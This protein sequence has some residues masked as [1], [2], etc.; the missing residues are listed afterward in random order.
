MSGYGF[1]K[2]LLLG[3]LMSSLAAESV[4]AGAWTR[5]KGG[6]YNQLTFNYYTADENF[7]DG[8]GRA[9]FENN[10]DFLDRN[11]AY[12]V[13]YGLSDSFTG[14]GSWSYKWLKY[15]DDSVEN[16][17]NGFSDLDLALKY[18]V[19]S[20]SGGVF[21]IQGLIKIPEAYDKNDAVPLGNSQYD[22]ELRLLYG[23]SLY[24][25]FPG[26][27]NVEAGYRFRAQ[28]P[29]DEF[30]YLLEAGVDITKSIYGRVKLD[31]ILGM[32]NTGN[33]SYTLENP[34]TTYDYDLGKLDV[35]VGWK[36]GKGWGIELGYRPEIYGK[37]T[38][39]GKNLSFTVIFQTQ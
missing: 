9:D 27:F 11:V 25:H 18:R 14:I 8:G 10:G 12:Y 34:T 32:G 29:A 6:M 36:I 5:E 19:F 28:A 16:T 30:R 26:Y 35:A 37:N 4:Y 17:T 39:A 33:S 3:I 7:G 21:A 2:I 20:R 15:E 24:P 23:Q 22:Y 1:L 38:A 13:E 31:G